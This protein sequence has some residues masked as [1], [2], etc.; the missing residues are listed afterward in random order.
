MQR[1]KGACLICGEPLVYLKQAEMMKCS[2]CGKEEPSYAKC[3]AGHYVC[4]ACH[5]KRGIESIM[6]YCAAAAGRD[7]IAMLT[8]MMND[9]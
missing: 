4:D 2:F 1:Q 8:E 9:P 5:A 3:G 6:R 7:P